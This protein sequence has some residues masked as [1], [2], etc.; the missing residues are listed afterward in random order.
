MKY[1]NVEDQC[2][3]ISLLLKMWNKIII[4]DRGKEGIGRKIG[5]GE[6]KGGHN[7]VWEENG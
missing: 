2:M 7:Q 4:K 3:D 6:E 1:N 5:E